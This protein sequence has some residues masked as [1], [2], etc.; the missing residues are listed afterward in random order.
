MPSNET[1]ELGNVDS[2]MFRCRHTSPEAVIGW[3][4]NESSVGHFP[5]FTTGSI[6]ENG[7][8]VV[9][10]LTIPARSEYNGTKVV[11]EAFFRDGSPTEATPPATLKFRLG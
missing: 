3:L 9:Y 6:N 8:V 11:C 2:V 7:A 4:V 1:V 5:D 10:T